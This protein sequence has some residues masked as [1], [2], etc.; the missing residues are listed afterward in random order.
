MEDMVAGTELGSYV[1]EAPI[2]RGLMASIYRARDSRTGAGILDD[3]RVVSSRNLPDRA[4]QQSPV[5]T[6]GLR[7]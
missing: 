3:Q 7:G 2:A 6:R 4:G 5:P 1:L